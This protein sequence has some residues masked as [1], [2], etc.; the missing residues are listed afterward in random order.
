MYFTQHYYLQEWV[1]YHV[2]SFCKVLKSAINLPMQQGK[3]AEVH[4]YGME[5]GLKC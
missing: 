4:L 5:W 3:H 1:L 2:N